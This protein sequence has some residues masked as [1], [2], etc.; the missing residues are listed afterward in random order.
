MARFRKRLEI[1]GPEEMERKFKM[2]NAK[3]GDDDYWEFLMAL[4]TFAEEY[5]Q[6]FQHHYGRKGFRASRHGSE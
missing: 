2:L 1:R 6:Q 4:L 3:H 5:E